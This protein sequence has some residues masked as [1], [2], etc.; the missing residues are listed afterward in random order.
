MSTPTERRAAPA[1]PLFLFAA[2]DLV[3]ALLML[4]G[5]GFSLAFGVVFAIGVVLAVLGGLALL[6][7]ALPE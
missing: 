7:N 4:I 5:G 3:L 2:V 1:I 6:K